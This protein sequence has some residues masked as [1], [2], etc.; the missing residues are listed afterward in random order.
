MAFHYK[1]N[2]IVFFED[3]IAMNRSA[4]MLSSFESTENS[5]FVHEELSYDMIAT[6]ICTPVSYTHL[7]VY[8]RQPLNAFQEKLI[9]NECLKRWICPLVLDCAI[10][11]WSIFVENTHD[12]FIYCS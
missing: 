4:S 12:G 9:Y 1:S 3:C 6:Y 8:K 11:T 2:I 7:D 5:F 10:C